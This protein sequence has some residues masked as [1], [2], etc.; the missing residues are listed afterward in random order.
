[1]TINA[2]RPDH[3]LKITPRDA[4]RFWKRV[5]KTSNCWYWTGYVRKGGYGRFN[6]STRLFSARGTAYYLTVAAHR[7]AY[8]IG[9][10]ILPSDLV[11]HKCKDARH[12]VRPSHLYDGSH[13]QNG[14]DMIDHGN[15]LYGRRNAAVK[16]NEDQ[17]LTIRAKHAA[18]L[19]TQTA[20]AEEFGVAQ[21]SIWFIVHRRTWRHLP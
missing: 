18:G 21:A 16:L 20:L 4:A 6:L 5:R 14:Q 9:T 8:Y 12:C 10:G 15:A 13:A 17:V 2:P 11:L 3:L 1:M 19:A 7:A